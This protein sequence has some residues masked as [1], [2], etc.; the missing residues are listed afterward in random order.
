MVR[1]ILRLGCLTL[2]PSRRTFKITKPK[3][4]AVPYGA[5]TV[6]ILHLLCDDLISGRYL[7]TGSKDS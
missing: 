2:P 7:A 6:A 1:D 3:A 4:V 5:V